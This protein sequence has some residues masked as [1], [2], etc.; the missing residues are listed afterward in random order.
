MPRDRALL[1]LDMAARRALRV[2]LEDL[3]HLAHPAHVQVLGEVPPDV[4][5]RLTDE[6]TV[7]STHTE[8]LDVS[9]VLLQE[10]LVTSRNNVHDILRVRREV[11]ERLERVIGR[12]GH[13]GHLASLLREEAGGRP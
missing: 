10:R 5:T 7:L 3:K 4:A 6:A 12:C 9:K 13:A 8:A 2:V 1:R 11:S